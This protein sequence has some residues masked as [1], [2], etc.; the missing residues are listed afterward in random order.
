MT[1]T[2]S[3]RHAPAARDATAPA[4]QRVRRLFSRYRRQGD[5]RARRDLIEHFLPL[6]RR[7]ARRYHVGREPLEDLQQVASLA[8][9]KAVDGYDEERS[10][11]F[12]SYA[13]PTIA[14]ELKRHF[15]DNGWAVHVP[16]GAQERALR[17]QRAMRRIREETGRRPR[18]AELARAADIPEPEVDAALGAYS[19][20]SATSLDAPAGNG[21]DGEGLTLADS[22][23]GVEEPGYELVTERVSIQPALRRLPAEDRRILFMR[24]VEGRTQSDIARRI[25]VSQ[26]QVSRLLRRILGRLRSAA[27]E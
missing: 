5:E 21:E 20:L 1:A 24:F 11:S 17:V 7:L 12:V 25:G 6:A 19:A 22:R 8:L 10:T 16:R 18:R 26:M 13:K 4:D 3:S 14:G 2:A 27:A 23:L 9:V 15:R